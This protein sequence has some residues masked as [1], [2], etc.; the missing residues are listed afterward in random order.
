VPSPKQLSRGAQAAREADR[1]GDV[2]KVVTS[3]G[4]RGVT[5]RSQIREEPGRLRRWQTSEGVVGS[6]ELTKLFAG[7]TLEGRR[8]VSGGKPK[9]GRVPR[10]TRRQEDK[11]P[12]EDEAQEGREFPFRT[13][14]SCGKSSRPQGLSPEAGRTLKSAVSYRSAGESGTPRKAH[15]L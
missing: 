8:R 2:R 6:R 1:R 7:Q 3:Y 10:K 5:Q 4:L 15:G 14:S 9:R 11:T 13:N 12:K